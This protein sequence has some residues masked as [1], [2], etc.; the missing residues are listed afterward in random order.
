M[1]DVVKIEIE[2]GHDPH[3]Q[4]NGKEKNNKIVPK[5]PNFLSNFARVRTLK[6]GKLVL[7]LILKKTSSPLSE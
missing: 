1:N 7:R 6:L 5:A 2:Q 4:E 3:I